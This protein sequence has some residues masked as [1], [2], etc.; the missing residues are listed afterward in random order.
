MAK[1]AGLC[2]RYLRGKAVSR[3]LG[4]CLVLVATLT[5]TIAVFRS[6][7]SIMV[8]LFGP[9]Y[10]YIG[11]G[12]TEVRQLMEQQFL[13][14]TSAVDSADA[15]AKMVVD[16]AARERANAI[17]SDRG[18]FF[19]TL[20]R[21]LVSEAAADAKLV[22]SSGFHARIGR[23]NLRR[24]GGT[25]HVVSMATLWWSDAHM[26][27]GGYTECPSYTHRRGDF[28]L[29]DNTEENAEESVF[30]PSCAIAVYP[31]YMRSLHSASDL[32]IYHRSAGFWAQDDATATSSSSSSTSS[33]GRNLRVKDEYL[34][35]EEELPSSGPA[36]RSKSSNR[37][38]STA[39]IL[40]MLGNAGAAEARMRMRS[41][42]L[43]Q[44]TQRSR[45]R[46]M[47]PSSILNEPL[48]K[49]VFS[50]SE[51]PKDDTGR[52]QR[53]GLL[54]AENFAYLFQA[55]ETARFDTDVT[56]RQSGFFRDG[57]YELLLMT[58]ADAFPETVSSWNDL[59]TRPIVPVKERRKMKDGLATVSWAHSHCFSMS[60]REDLVVALMNASLP[61]DVYGRGCLSNSGAPVAHMGTIR[62]S[63]EKRSKEEESFRKYKFHLA[64]ENSICD[65]YVTEKLYFALARGQVPIYLGAPNILDFAPASDS[66][67]N[68]LD[69]PSA[70]A[71]SQ[72]LIALDEDDE[73]YMKYHA[74][75]TRPISTYGKALRRALAELVPLGRA[76]SGG[77]FSQENKNKQNDVEGLW[78][79]C[80]LCYAMQRAE[81]GG[82][83]EQIMRPRP[84]EPLQCRVPL[85]VG[86]QG[87]WSLGNGTGI[88]WAPVGV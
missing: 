88:G 66:F 29:D 19:V 65:D 61:I 85:T 33:S 72:H 5:C 7:R 74:W 30:V 13:M 70:E 2:I 35:S 50:N 78:Y 60:G 49:P 8:F 57:G 34:I 52:R 6:R 46:K 67:I 32:L 24:E 45:R 38:T 41:L 18:Q 12:T 14:R 3:I 9:E 59:F 81:K 16:A 21:D 44:Q 54:A 58:K 86:A 69:F 53:H 42:G 76:T 40:S 87:D 39:Q 62:T 10:G 11:L 51:L 79:R 83:A 64:L 84:V 27:L 43:G 48:M 75:R 71:L 17:Y 47:Y 25:V 31:E 15:R 77:P 4:A 82:S 80:G 1:S 56:Y 28:E 26:W 68:A 36:K 23:R 20:A 37:K 22:S 63:R 73:L 55:N